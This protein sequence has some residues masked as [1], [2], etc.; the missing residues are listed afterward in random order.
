MRLPYRARRAQ[1]ITTPFVTARAAS[2][3]VPAPVL[4]DAAAKRAAIL[5]WRRQLDGD[6]SVISDSDSDG[7][8]SDTSSVS[9]DDQGGVGVGADVKLSLGNRA[10]RL[11]RGRRSGPRH[12]SRQFEDSASSDEGSISS[13]DSM[14]SAGSDV[15]GLDVDATVDVGALAAARVSVGVKRFA[16]PL[17]LDSRSDDYEDEAKDDDEKEEDDEED[18][19]EDSD[20]SSDDSDSSDDD[21]D[22]EEDDVIKVLVP[23]AEV[24]D[25][26]KVLVDSAAAA[27]ASDEI[28]VLVQ[29]PASTPCACKTVPLPTGPLA[30]LFIKRPAESPSTAD[31]LVPA[32]STVAA[33]SFEV[34]IPVLADP[35]TGFAIPAHLGIE[36]DSVA[37]TTLSSFTL[38]VDSCAL[39]ALP[40]SALA[41]L[42]VASLKRHRSRRTMAH[43]V[44]TDEKQ[45]CLS[46]ETNSRNAAENV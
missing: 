43:H 3:S 24:S 6:D 22:D 37:P 2:P 13:E 44:V 39:V 34:D 8:S 28:Q 14:S 16:P 33:R 45:L 40:A 20:S 25:E 9:S 41:L 26:I 31:P 36:A 30:D 1:A 11:R 18:E 32:G 10:H 21:S 7:V 12:I 38:S 27:Q 17:A 23:G 29:A 15:Q 19:E 35:V 5:V 42:V 4:K 46:F